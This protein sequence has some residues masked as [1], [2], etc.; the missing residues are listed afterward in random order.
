MD[1]ADFEQNYS[2]EIFE[3]FIDELDAQGIDW[4]YRLI[5]WHED[6]YGDI[7]DKMAQEYGVTD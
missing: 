5:N 4:Q 6:I 1:Y 7:L 2:K 3:K